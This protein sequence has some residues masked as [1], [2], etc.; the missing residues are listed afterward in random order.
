MLLADVLVLAAVGVSFAA[1]AV[2]SVLGR[3]DPAVARDK[4]II[5]AVAWPIEGDAAPELTPA[6]VAALWVE[7]ADQFERSYADADRAEQLQ[8]LAERAPEFADI[9]WRQYADLYLVPDGGEAA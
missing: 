3:P 2:G 7:Y 1:I 6:L 8:I 5:D 9:D 4:T